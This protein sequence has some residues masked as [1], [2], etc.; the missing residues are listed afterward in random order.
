[1][2]WE[3]KLKSLYEAFETFIYCTHFKKNKDSL[4]IIMDDSR[5]LLN[6]LNV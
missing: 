5:L 2:K 6:L 1:M 3:L 4:F